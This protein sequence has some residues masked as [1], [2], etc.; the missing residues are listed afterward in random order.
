MLNILSLLVVVLVKC[1]MLVVVVVLVDLRTN[2]PGLP[3]SAPSYSVSTAPDYTV[4]VGAGGGLWFHQT[5]METQDQILELSNTRGYPSTFELEQLVEMVDGGSG[6]VVHK[7][8]PA[9]PGG[10]GG[11]GAGYGYG[12]VYRWCRSNASPDPNHPAVQ[13]YQGMVVVVS[14]IPPNYQGGGGAGVVLMVVLVLANKELELVVLDSSKYYCIT[15][16]YQLRERISLGRWWMVCWWW[17]WWWSTAEQHGGIGGGGGTVYNLVDTLAGGGFNAG[18]DG[19]PLQ[20]P[21]DCWILMEKTLVVEEVEVDNQNQPS[22]QGGSGI[23]IVRYQ[24]GSIDS[25]TA[26]ATGGS[27]SFY[28]GKTIHTFASTGDFNNTTGAPLN[29]GC[30]SWSWWWRWWR[31][32]WRWCWWYS[33]AGR[34]YRNDDVTISPG[35]QTVT[36][37][38]G[39]KGGNG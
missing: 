4:T 20:I 6:V 17:R 38:A 19:D 22:G 9:L 34:F 39:G 36:V 35:P 27:I 3:V 31:Y 10:S 14:G 30:K 16:I 28:N 8:E 37:G 2:M 15:S 23:V 26:K 32:W 12:S 33:G 18:G 29:C 5:K 24:I 13:G 11:G 25:G 1:R 21:L 7:L